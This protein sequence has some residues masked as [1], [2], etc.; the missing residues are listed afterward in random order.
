MKSRKLVGV[1]CATMSSLLLFGGNGSSLSAPGRFAVAILCARGI[2]GAKRLV[3]RAKARAK[4]ETCD[5]YTGENE[6]ATCEQKNERESNFYGDNIYDDDDSDDGDDGEI[7]YQV[8]DFWEILEDKKK[9]F[10]LLL[11]LKSTQ[12]NCYDDYRP[13]D[14]P[15]VVDSSYLKNCSKEVR[16]NYEGPYKFQ[17]RNGGFTVVLYIYRGY[18]AFGDTEGKFKTFSTGD[19]VRMLNT[20]SSKGRNIIVID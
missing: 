6:N 16:G 2:L 14:S 11:D 4:L 15:L 3:G 10:E 9:L 18:S 20:W 7:V 19:I 17:Y 13:I 12:A 8:D 1:L 5:T